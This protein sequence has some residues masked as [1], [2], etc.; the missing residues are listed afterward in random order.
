MSRNIERKGQPENLGQKEKLGISFS[1]ITISG[2]PG[3]GNTVL[4]QGLAKRYGVKLIP[5]GQMYRKNIEETNIPVIDYTK[6]PIKRDEKIDKMQAIVIKRAIE[7]AGQPIIIESKLAGVIATE[8][9]SQTDAGQIALSPVIR[10]LV[11]AEEEV[12]SKRIHKREKE[13]HPNFKATQEEI[14]D[15]TTNRW[16]K[17]LARYRLIHPQLANIDP[18][19]PKNADKFYDFVIDTTNL[20]PKETV[21]K[22]HDFLQNRGL[23]N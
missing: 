5:I 14:K 8:V 17:D 4:A 3:S 16:K 21:Q 11:T 6:R 7:T 20:S 2:K 9:M 12:R 23:V 19:D 13:K 15:K 22:V 1:L 10:I 18:W